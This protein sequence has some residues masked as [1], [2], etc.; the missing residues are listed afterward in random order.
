MKKLNLS[1]H[2]IDFTRNLFTLKNLINTGF[3][4]FGVLLLIGPAIQNGFPILHSDSGTYLLEGFNHKIP[5]SR[6]LSYCLFV[7]YTSRVFSIW[8]VIIT[9]AIFVYWMIWLTVNTLLGKKG[10]A[11]LTFTI[12]A[13]LSVTTGISY[14]VSQIMPDIFLS[15][16]FLGIFV[17]LFR[18]KLPWLTLA[19]IGWIIWISLIVHLSNLPVITGVLTALLALLVILN[20]T[21]KVLFSSKM[22]FLYAVMIISWL[23]NPVISLYQGEGLQ[24]SNSSNIVFFSRLLQAGAAQ[25]FIKDKCNEDKSYYLC[26]YADEIDKYNRLD[27]FLW[28]DSSFLYDHPCREKTW[29]NCWRERNAEFGVV[30]S[31]ILSYPPSRKIYLNAV[32]NDFLLQ[33]RSFELTTYVSFKAGSHID[34][35][36][37]RYYASDY[38]SFLNS[39]QNCG[40]LV[41]SHQ[42]YIIRWSIYLSLL[43]LIGLVIKYKDYLNFRSPFFNLFLIILGGWLING[44]LT[45]SLAVVSHRF[46]G[47][48][49]WLLPMLVILMIYKEYSGK[50][51]VSQD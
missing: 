32:W 2:F 17:L 40:D 34:Y 50:K 45:A 26:K 15:V 23:T 13:I 16:A 27:V 29:D 19:F 8:S 4:I 25:T 47:R 33:L 38:K 11:W 1:I 21:F 51:S 42:K 3:F 24:M 28:E 46:L 14:Y 30:N 44:V 37:K 48:F 5:V 18:Q 41:F 20:K 22:I 10:T 39:R 7:K 43:I 49:I 9:Q 35:P 6:P 12:I 36:L 31:E